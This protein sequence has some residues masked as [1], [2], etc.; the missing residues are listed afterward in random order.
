MERLAG[1]DG[2]DLAVRERDPLGDPGERLGTG[3][4]RGEDGAQL[5]PWLERDH[6]RIPLGQHTGQLAGA[7]PDVEGGRVVA[8]GEQVECLRRPVRPAPLV[9]LGGEVEA[10]RLLRQPTPASRK[11]RFS[12]SISRAMTSRWIWFVPS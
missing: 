8:D 12:F 1:E 2:V 5:I 6:A 4:P 3:H 11:A 7:R 10:A 9:C